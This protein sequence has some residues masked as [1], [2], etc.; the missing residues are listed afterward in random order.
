[1]M[2]LTDG[3]G[4]FYEGDIIELGKKTCTIGIKKTIE[5][6]NKRHFYLHLVIAPTK[7]IDR[8][9]WCLE[10]ATEIGVDEITPLICKRSERT[11]VKHERLNG[12]LISAM[13]QSLKTY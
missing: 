6:Y 9:E 13:K 11:V 3:K 5:A 4:N 2:Q 10:K 8:L 12:I 1:M 7:N